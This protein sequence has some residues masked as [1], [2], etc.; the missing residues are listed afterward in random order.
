ME[1]STIE[2]LFKTIFRTINM[3]A[4]L[5]ITLNIFFQVFPLSYN[6]F[7]KLEIKTV[8]WERSQN[9]FKDGS[10]IIL[11]ACNYHCKSRQN[12]CMLQRRYQ[13]GNKCSSENTPST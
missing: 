7:L 9:T 12:N 2:M 3:S 6:Y 13:L 5:I 10:S 8:V 1:C 4:I 11:P